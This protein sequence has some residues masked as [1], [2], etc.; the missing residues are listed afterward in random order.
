MSSGQQ[1]WRDVENGVRDEGPPLK[2]SRCPRI[3]S[4]EDRGLCR[5]CDRLLTQLTTDFRLGKIHP[6]RP[7]LQ[8]NLLKVIRLLVAGYDP[9]KME[10]VPGNFM[11]AGVFRELSEDEL[12]EVIDL[13]EG[14]KRT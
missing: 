1:Y 10:D 11:K 9:N 3:L 14:R 13:V 5:D 12:W 4:F 7:E 2:C 8:E 6:P